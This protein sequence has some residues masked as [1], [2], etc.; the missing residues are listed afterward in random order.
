METLIVICH[1]RN[2]FAFADDISREEIRRGFQ[3][4]AEKLRDGNRGTSGE[5]MRG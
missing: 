1:V 4:P 5:R 2:A 3:C